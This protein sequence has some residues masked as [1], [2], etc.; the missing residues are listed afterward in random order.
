MAPF[1]LSCLGPPVLYG[2]DGDPIRFRTR[3]HFALL[4]YLAV[5]PGIPHRRDRLA[6]LLW[7]AAD[8]DEARHSLATAL[9]MIRGRLGT[10][11]LDTDRD[12]VR[13]MPGRIV[14]DLQTLDHLD[15]DDLDEGPLG[16][17]LEEFDIPDA[18]DFQQW[19]DGQHAR[20][21]PAVHTAMASRIEQSRRRGDS[22]RMEALGH[23]LQRIDDLSE[24][25]ARAVLEA[26]AMAGDRIGALRSFDRWRARLAD[27]LGAHP[28]AQ[29]ERMAERLRRGGWQR[30]TIALLAPVPTEQWKERSFVGRGTEF[31]ACYDRWERVQQGEPQHLLVRGE[32]GIGKTTLVERLTTSMALEGASVARIQC[33][34]LERELP[35]GV[36]GSLVNHLLD[37]PGASG[38]PPEQLAELGRLTA[39]VRQRYPSLP[40]P[41]ESTGESAR[42]LYTEAVMA[43]VE[44]VAEEHP[45]VLVIDDIHLA[46]ATSLT[47]LHLMLRRLEALPLM[48]M[49][50]ASSA[51]EAETPSSRRFLDNAASLTLTPMVLGPLSDGESAE[52]LELLLTEAGDPGPAVRRAVLAGARGNPMVLELLVGD[53]RRRG[54]GCLALSVSAMT[55]RAE[56]PPK[57]TFQRLVE[58]TL[59]ALNGEERSVVELAAILGQRLNDLAMYTMVDLPVARTMR[60]MTSLTSHRILRDA[61]SHL[62]FAN[63]FI[64]GQCYV[65]TG[66]PLRRMLHG[67]VAERLLLAD[68]GD[69]AIPGLEI[70]WHLVR[71]DRL[72]EAIPFLLAG[73]KESI[74]RGAPHEADLALSTG[75]PALTGQPRRT[76]ILLLAEAQQE[77]GRWSDSLRLL[78]EAREAFSES[79]ESCREVLRIGNDRWLGN[80]TDSRLEDATDALLRIAESDIDIEVRAK[81][82]SSSTLLIS[83][84]RRSI[85]IERLGSVAAMLQACECDDYIRIHLLHA[86]AWFQAHTGSPQTALPTLWQG[87][88]LIRQTGTASSIATRTLLGTGVTLCQGGM[89]QEAAPLLREAY[90]FAKRLDNPG[91]TANAASGMALVQG[92]LG[93]AR[94]QADWGR[95]AIRISTANEWGICLLSA[96]Y[97]RGVGLCLDERFEEAE[98]SLDEIDARFGK[99]RPEWL[100]QAWQLCKADVLSL[101]G[102]ERRALASARKATS[103]G[104]SELLHPCFA[105]QYAR[106]VARSGLVDGKIPIALARITELIANLPVY[107]LKDQAEILAASA[108]LEQADTGLPSQRW[109]EVAHRLETLPSSIGLLMR[110]FG[111]TGE[112]KGA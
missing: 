32:S 28:S 4:L 49:L 39:K 24:E 86:L 30:P 51:A 92:R 16:P 29:L 75:L 5:E 18:V 22:R 19:K 106:W 74:R 41:L 60:A 85:D 34:E 1:R 107:D 99:G 8:V 15:P 11:L 82:L 112:M 53:W 38:T 61:G 109:M 44:A 72:H 35:F 87:V 65:G 97:D 63:E 80:L 94:A 88:A 84:S 7:S 17:F 102:R 3:K 21:L 98:A 2:P 90:E 78:D 73:G 26:R 36:T 45:V 6:T 31:R 69:E 71:A 58:G 9:S 14:T 79:E 103:H 101:A 42:I 40:A 37:L 62:E 46:D 48:M 25:A 110:R 55:P 68:G 43:L 59:A 108:V 12:T 50:T 54:D 96:A 66:A 57:E 76:A 23:R 111:M 64:R 27:E 104:E 33:Y 83:C 81:A 91:L 105:G 70:A 77:L 100:R 47:V 20:L 56:R 93:D 52:L 89:Y 13:L 95:H 67:L 10:D